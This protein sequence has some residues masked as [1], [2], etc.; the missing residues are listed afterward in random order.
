[1]ASLRARLAAVFGLFSGVARA[2]GD[3][4]DPGGSSAGT[5]AA[6]ASTG[7]SAASASS[8][9]DSQSTNSGSGSGGTTDNPSASTSGTTVADVT[10]GEYVE[11]EANCAHVDDCDAY[12]LVDYGNL[13]DCELACEANGAVFANAGCP[14]EFEAL[15]DCVTETTCEDLR[16]YLD[17]PRGSGVCS[18]EITTLEVCAT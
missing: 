4:G 16:L 6:T 7:A 8:S 13:A 5:T 18:D 14:D 9:S 17:D 2:G 10:G 11:C 15:T 3:E 12:D 1:M